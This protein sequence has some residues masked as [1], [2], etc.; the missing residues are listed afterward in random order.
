MKAATTDEHTIARNT[1]GPGTLALSLRRHVGHRRCRRLAPT[2][3]RDHAGDRAVATFGPCRRSQQ[4]GPNTVAASA[5]A[6]LPGS[7]TIGAGPRHHRHS[8]I[9]LC[10][11]ISAK[12][13][14]ARLRSLTAPV[15]NSSVRNHAASWQI[16]T[17]AARGPWSGHRR[18]RS[19]AD[20]QRISRWA[21]PQWSRV[22]QGNAQRGASD[23]IR[24]LRR[25]KRRK[26]VAGGAN[27]L[28]HTDA[29]EVGG[30]RS[31]LRCGPPINV[32]KVAGSGCVQFRVIRVVQP[33][34]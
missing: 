32:H 8:D 25:R 33:F 11:S 4:R 21:H 18:W 23:R 2:L 24:T 3:D 17:A 15:S 10:G 16:T 26:R 14:R 13:V 28:R 31:T 6:S 30:T 9:W 7:S 12:S 1:A 27:Q 22:R 20:P 29:T 34:G 5:F 19:D